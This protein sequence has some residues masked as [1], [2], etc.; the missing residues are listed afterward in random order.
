[1]LIWQGAFGQQR[2]ELNQTEA[3]EP[4]LEAMRVQQ[5]SAYLETRCFKALNT[6]K[7]LPKLTLK[8]DG[9]DRNDVCINADGTPVAVPTCSTHKKFHYTRT[10]VQRRFLP[11]TTQTETRSQW[12]DIPFTKQTVTAKLAR[13]KPFVQAGPDAC[14]YRLLT[15]VLGMRRVDHFVPEARPPQHPVRP[16]HDR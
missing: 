15:K 13:S 9:A 1:M 16:R 6:L 11:V 8:T 12:V 4:I 10:I 5:N 7:C 14:V 3:C 2:I